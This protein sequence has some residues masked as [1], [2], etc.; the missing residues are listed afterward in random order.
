MALTASSPNFNEDRLISG[1][2]VTGRKLGRQ[3][4]F[5][6]ANIDANVNGLVNG[7]YGVVAELRET[8]YLGVMNIGVKPTVDSNLQKTTEIFL[9]DFNDN[10]YGEYLVCELLFKI[11]EERKFASL[12]LLKQQIKED[13]LYAKERFKLTGITTKS[14]QNYFTEKRVF[15]SS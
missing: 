15:K 3:L 8:K 13:I 1:R 5:P 14:E 6:T 4:G 10:I 11:R 2:V 12:E 7:V 9:L